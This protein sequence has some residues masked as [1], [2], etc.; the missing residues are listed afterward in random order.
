MTE[1]ERYREAATATLEQLAWVIDYLHRIGKPRIAEAL[2][3]NWVDIA[4]RARLID[5]A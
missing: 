1:S 2:R 4:K 3:R 5:D